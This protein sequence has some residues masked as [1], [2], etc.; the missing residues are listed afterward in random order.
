[1]GIVD[2]LL[3][4]WPRLTGGLWVSIQL[5]ALTFVIGIPTGLLLAIAMLTKRRLLRYVAVTVVEIG[6]GMPALVLLQL[7]YYGLPIT[8]PAF[9]SAG[10][11]LGLTTAAYTSEI[12]RGGLQAVPEGEIES[13]QALG[14][15]P[16]WV[17]RD[18]IVP[19]GMRIALPAL[20]GFCVLMFQ[21]TTL[22]FTIAIPELMS[23]TRSIAGSTFHFFNLFVIAGLMYGAITITA[24]V[25]V[26]RLERRL[27]RHLY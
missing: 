5:A 25:L 1:M 10:I 23:Q 8:L 16:F 20:V 27:S 26:D 19:Q 15:K 9:L 2:D 22:A 7:V 14:I 13:A 11:A 6:R 17:M 18:V 24:S 4:Y 21:A 3:T 12:I